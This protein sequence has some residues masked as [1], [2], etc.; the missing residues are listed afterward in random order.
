MTENR[1]ARPKNPDP[2]QGYIGIDSHEICGML[3]PIGN[4]L[5]EV[6]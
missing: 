4:N 5:K 2:E 6:I 1:Q 3:S